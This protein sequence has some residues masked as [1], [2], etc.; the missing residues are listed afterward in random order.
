MPLAEEL[1][2]TSQGPLLNVVQSYKK[3]KAFPLI[4][5]AGIVS[6]FPVSYPTA[7]PIFGPSLPLFQ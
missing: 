3:W 4:V 5:G 1:F 2:R 6:W 7:F